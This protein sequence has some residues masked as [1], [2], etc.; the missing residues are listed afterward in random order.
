MLLAIKQAIRDL[1]LTVKELANYIVILLSF[2]LL[3]LVLNLADTI[4]LI[5]VV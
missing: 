2:P 4:L 1:S 3:L 5:T